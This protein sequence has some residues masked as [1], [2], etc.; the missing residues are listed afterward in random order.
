ML[1]FELLGLAG[2]FMFSAALVPQMIKV[3]RTK[4]AKDIKGLWPIYIPCSME[5]IGGITLMLMKCRYDRLE[6]NADAIDDHGKVMTTP[7]EAQ[8]QVVLTPKR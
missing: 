5:L 2:S 8:F 3:Y 1:L 7:N 6:R 4:S